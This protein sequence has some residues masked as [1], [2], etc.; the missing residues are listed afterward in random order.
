MKE[1]L[2]TNLA[3]NRGLEEVKHEIEHYI[4]KLPHIGTPLPKTWVRVQEQLEKDPR[5]YIS[6]DEYLSICR[7]NGFA[8]TEDALQLSD[9]LRYIGVFLHFQ[10]EPLLR[11]I[12]ILKLKWGT[13]AVY[14]VLDNPSVIRN[15]GRLHASNWRRIWDA[16][17]YEDKRYELLAVDDGFPAML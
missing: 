11:Q 7:D 9:Y 8:K 2:A 13:D 10:D 16:P 15:L 5:N 1:V 6:L 3:T 4:R 14:K 12:V 17:E